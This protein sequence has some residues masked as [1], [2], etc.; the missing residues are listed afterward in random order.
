[1][2]AVCAPRP[3]LKGELDIIPS[4]S[5]LHR[6]LI[7][8]ALAKGQSSVTPF[9]ASQDIEATLA[10]IRYLGAEARVESG[11]ILVNSQ[12]LAPRGGELDVHESGSTLRFVIPVALCSAVR[13]RVVGREGLARRPLSV[14]DELFGAL[15]LSFIHPAGSCLPLELQGPLLSGDFSLRGDV[16]SQFISGLLMAL[17]L[18]S[19]VSRVIL[20][21]P[22]ESA[23]YAAMTVSALR[24]FGIEIGL[25]EAGKSGFPFGGWTVK[26][27]QAYHPGKRRAEGDWSGAAFWVAANA[28]GADIR[29]RG[30]DRA[31]LQP[32]RRIEDICR[33]SPSE[34]DVSACPDLLPVLAVWAG[35]SGRAVKIRGAARVRIKECD[36]VAAMAKELNAIGG[37]ARELPDGLDIEPVDEYSGGAVSGWNDHRVVMALAVASLKS[38]NAIA[39]DGAQAVAKSYPGF[40]EDFKALGGECHVE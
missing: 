33:E 22:L 13:T 34:V 11:E 3:L 6:L 21:T 25:E 23:E 9:I 10:A 14:Y 35:L 12:G 36:R 16:S 37:K 1:V 26:G 20:S 31:S 18:L 32:D 24:D 30:L 38:R 8:S 29:L 27:P 28:L 5:S 40:F 4:K 2:K 15:G 19:G 17:P 7:C 39:I